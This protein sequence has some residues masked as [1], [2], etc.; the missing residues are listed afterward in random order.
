MIVNCLFSDTAK[1]N[2]IC[3]ELGYSSNMEHRISWPLKLVNRSQYNLEYDC[4]FK[5]L[6]S[7]SLFWLTI[8]RLDSMSFTFS[9][10][11]SSLP[12]NLKYRIEN[13]LSYLSSKVDAFNVLNL[14]ALEFYL[15][16]FLLVLYETK[17]NSRRLYNDKYGNIELDSVYA[18]LFNDYLNFFLPVNER[19]VNFPTFTDPRQA[20]QDLSSS[21]LIPSHNKHHTSLLRH[22]VQKSV[23]EDSISILNEPDTISDMKKIDT[24]IRL[25]VDVLVNSFADTSEQQFVSLVNKNNQYSD[26][27]I[28]GIL[29]ETSTTASKSFLPKNLSFSSHSPVKLNDPKIFLANIETVFALSM[30]L[31]HFHLFSNAFPV[32][33]SG[34]HSSQ[35]INQLNDSLCFNSY[36]KPNK[37]VPVQAKSP[38]DELRMYL[39]Q[40]KLFYLFFY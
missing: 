5:F 29:N 8:F 13:G 19:D 15:I 7:N 21:S 33:S 34:L 22:V 9:L 37:S 10:E 18:D 3:N 1:I 32:M 23:T 16:H 4:I 39:L 6:N 2:Y 20:K 36:R 17:S 14:T 24:F 31:K 11:T 38:I 25:F 40:S 28:S 30:T 12:P 27:S 26:N 35:E